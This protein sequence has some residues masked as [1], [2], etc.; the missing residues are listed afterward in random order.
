MSAVNA[1]RR[2]AVAGLL[3]GIAIGAAVGATTLTGA[4]S[5]APPGPPP[6]VLH[7]AKVLADPGADVTLSAGLACPGLA[8]TSDACDVRSALAHVLSERTDGWS[9]IV[10]RADGGGYRFVVPGDA[11]GD[12]GLSY[13]LEFRTV[14]GAAVRL[15]DGGAATPFRVVT[16]A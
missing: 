14:G 8:A 7:V 2:L 12:D 11:V 13:W 3:A 1:R 9:E 4:S 16:T 6:V 10:G 15:P 5:E